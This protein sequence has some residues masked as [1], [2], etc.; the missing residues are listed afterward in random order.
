MA[1]FTHVPAG[2]RDRCRGVSPKAPH[3]SGGEGGRRRPVVVAGAAIDPSQLSSLVGALARLGWT[4]IGSPG[5]FGVQS[6]SAM[7][8]TANPQV[9]AER[10]S[11]SYQASCGLRPARPRC[12]EITRSPPSPRGSRVPGSDRLYRDRLMV[13]GAKWLARRGVLFLDESSERTAMPS[14]RVVS[15]VRCLVVDRGRRRATES[16]SGDHRGGKFLPQSQP[17][18]G[19]SRALH[20]P[21]GCGQHPRLVTVT[22]LGRSE[23]NSSG[24]SSSS[25]GATS[26]HSHRVGGTASVT[27]VAVTI[28]QPLGPRRVTKTSTEVPSGRPS[29]GASG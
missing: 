19:Q 13:D 2:C 6:R 22:H 20:Q 5:I 12:D 3:S 10:K 28:C 9:V 14:C 4:R 21:H 27:L 25:S 8:S 24:R 29:T 17:K 16:A 26:R 1:D 15:S 7:C 23:R 11:E 18:S